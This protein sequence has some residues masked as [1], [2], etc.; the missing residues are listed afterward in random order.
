[1]AVSLLLGV[2]HHHTTPV[3]PQSNGRTERFNRILKEMLQILVNNDSKQ[4][5]SQL[6]MRC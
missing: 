3:H 2:E 4:W 1:M 5:Q 6:D